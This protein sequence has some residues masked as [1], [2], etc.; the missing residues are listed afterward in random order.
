MATLLLII[1]YI[2]FISLGLPDA[3]LGSGWPVMQP[4]LNVPY[5]FAGFIQVIISG[6]TILSSMFSGLLLKRFGTGKLTTLSVALTAAALLGF[7]LAPSFLWILPAAIPLGLGAG[8]VDAGLNAYVADHYESRHM[9]WLHSFWGVGALG[10]PMILSVLLHKGFP[11][12][13]G[14]RSVGIF[15]CILVFVLI[16]AIPL[17]DKVKS[18]K[19]T[20][21]VTEPGD[22]VSFL[23][24]LKIKGVPMALLVF[25][26]YCGIE[27]SMGLW[28]G[29]FL[30]KVKGLNPAETASW[31]SFFFGSITLGRFLT[32]FLTYRW[33]N[34]TLIRRGAIIVLSGILL[35]LLPLSLPLTLLGFLMVGFGLA[36]IFPSMLHET[37]VRF[38]KENSQAIMGFQM[39]VAYMGATFLPPLFGFI[40]SERTL[41][42]LPVFLL[43][44]IV[45]LIV[46]FERLRMITDDMGA[47]AYEN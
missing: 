9:S 44:Y 31:V 10:G 34:N 15:Q 37:P 11:W 20:K 35:M 36:P 2:A 32:G 7:S 41:Y 38:G 29:S 47:I 17:W 33:S 5:G 13:S 39:A 21:G 26:F 12:R 1:I 23:G 8:A 3:L 19:S 22:Q 43:G 6:G 25:L 28:G 24:A 42:L 30:F 27:S 14:Y 40:A 45:F 46:C 4:D 18:R 16:A